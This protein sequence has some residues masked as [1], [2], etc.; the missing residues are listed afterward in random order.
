MIR[1]ILQ[2]TLVRISDRPGII[3][4]TG[5]AQ[6]S[7]GGGD[8]PYGLSYPDAP[9]GCTASA[10]SPLYA[11]NSRKLLYTRRSAPR[12]RLNDVTA[13]AAMAQSVDA[14]A[15]LAADGASVSVTLAEGSASAEQRSD[16]CV[17][18]SLVTRQDAGAPLHLQPGG[19]LQLVFAP[20]TAP[21]PVELTT[22]Y[23][24]LG[25]DDESSAETPV[26]ELAGLLADGTITA[27]TLCW[28]ETTV[29]GSSTTF[30]N[31]VTASSVLGLALSAHSLVR[32][33]SHATPGFLAAVLLSVGGAQ[34]FWSSDGGCYGRC[35]NG[36][37]AGSAGDGPCDDGNTACCHE[38]NAYI[39]EIHACECLDTSYCAPQVADATHDEC[40]RWQL[41]AHQEGWGDAAMRIHA[42]GVLQIENFAYIDNNFVTTGVFDACL[43]PSRCY[44]ITVSG[45]P[46]ATW[47]IHDALGFVVVE[48]SGPF[49]HEVCHC[50]HYG[51]DACSDCTGVVAPAGGTSGGC[52]PDG[53]ILHGDRCLLT[54]AQESATLPVSCFNGTIRTPTMCCAAGT[55]WSGETDATCEQCARG[56]VDIDGNPWTPCEKCPA[57]TY[58]NEAGA[59]EC[60]DCDVGT[61]AIVGSSL[62]SNCATG[63]YDGDSNP[64]TP[65]A[66]CPAGTYSDIASATACKP[67][68]AATHST[69]AAT[70][71][72]ILIAPYGPHV[73]MSENLV[74][75]PVSQVVD[76]SQ[77]GLFGAGDWNGDG[78][79]DA[80]VYLREDVANQILLSD[81]HGFKNVT[82]TLMERTDR[83]D[84]RPDGNYRNW[85]NYVDAIPGDWNGD[86]MMDALVVNSG[87]E[88]M[89][90]ILIADGQENFTSRLLDRAWNLSIGISA[91]GDWN[92]DGTMDVLFVNSV[93]NG[94]AQIVNR[95]AANEIL[96]FNGQGNFTSTLMER[97]NRSSASTDVVA[98]DWNG[99]GMMDALV[100]NVDLVDFSAVSTMF[101]ILMSDG[102][103]SFTSRLM[104]PVFVPTTQFG[105]S[106]CPPALIAGDWNGDGMMDALVANC[107]ADPMFEVLISNGQGTFTSMLLRP[108]QLVSNVMGGMGVL[109]SPELTAGDWNGDGMMDALVLWPGVSAEILLSNGQGS[110]DSIVYEPIESGW[111]SS[112]GSSLVALDTLTHRPVAGDWNGD[113]RTDFAYAGK[114]WVWRR[115]GTVVSTV[116]NRNTFPSGV[117]VGDWNGDGM[118]DALVVNSDFS[119][120]WYSFIWEMMHAQSYFDAANEILLSDGQ[121]SFT[122]TLMDR[123]D[124]SASPIAADWNGDGM[125]DLLVLDPAGFEI[126]LSDGQDFASSGE[127]IVPACAGCDAS[128]VAGDW[129]SDGMMDALVV[130]RAGIEILLSDGQGS[131]TSTLMER[132]DDS[133]GVVAGD[134]NSDGM[135][136]ALVVN[137]AGIEILLSDGQGNFTSTLMGRSDD[138]TGVV[139]GDWNGD[140]MMDAFVFGSTAEVLISDGQGTFNSTLVDFVVQYDR[141]RGAAAGDWNGDGMMDVLVAHMGENE[142]LL[143]DGQGSFTSTRMENSGMESMGVAAGDFN[144]D[145]TMHALIV[146]AAEPI[147]HIWYDACPDDGYSPAANAFFDVTCYKCPRHTTDT[148]R[149]VQGCQLC[150]AGKLGPD[151]GLGRDQR[152][153]CIP[154]EAGTARNLT[155]LMCGECPVGKYAAAG[156]DLCAVCPAGQ[157]TKTKSSRASGCIQCGAGSGPNTNSTACEP[158]SGSQYSISGQCQDCA[159]PHVVNAERTACSACPAGTGPNTDRTQCISC[160]GATY[161]TIGQCQE[162]AAPN[163]VDGAHQ[164]CFACSPG[165]EPNANRT[166]C[167]DCTDAM[168][169]Q[170]GVRC[171][172]CDDVVDSQATRCF[173]CS[174]GEGPNANG[175]A[176]ELCSGSQYGIMGRCQDC[177]TPHVVNA[178]RTAC[179]ACPA[180]TGPN[181]DRTQC[182]S[183]TGATYST[184]GQ[185][186]EC[187][188]PNVVDGAHQ[189]CF[190]CSP[191]EEPNVNRTSCVQCKGNKVALVGICSLCSSARLANDA[192]TECIDMNER[193]TALTD[194]QVVED[195]LVQNTS[196]TL[197]ETSLIVNTS[198]M[199][200]SVFHAAFKTDLASA[201]RLRK[202]Q[203][204]IEVSELN[205]IRRQLQGGEQLANA[206]QVTIAIE[207]PNVIDILRSLVWQLE[208][209]SSDFRMTP[210]GALVT[211]DPPTFAFVCPQGMMRAS[212]TEQCSACPGDE[213]ATIDQIGCKLCPARTKPSH[214][215]S[216]C[217]CEDGSYSIRELPMI[218]CFDIGFV[219]DIRLE[220]NAATGCYQCPAVPKCLECHVAESTQ[221]TLGAGYRFATGDERVNQTRFAFKCPVKS[222]CPAQPLVAQQTRNGVRLIVN[223][224]STGHTGLLCAKCLSGWKSNLKGVCEQCSTS[225]GWTNPVL[226]LLIGF[227]IVYIT[228]RKL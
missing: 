210:T 98:G 17:M 157:V 109:G 191:G 76:G 150:P 123:S 151:A 30:G 93:Y 22:F 205:T 79:M 215:R 194:I 65:C 192:H 68:P 193:T 204:Q 64:S 146:N 43:H 89:F 140:G 162:C 188:A 122:S 48:G 75:T 81:G 36:R 52:D 118:M 179:S 11:S 207:L 221:V 14:A 73:P 172:Q 100:V 129:N 108:A 59:T 29:D 131:F 214:D 47:S 136:D 111:G 144:G 95:G 182:I 139:A 54:C 8:A 132:S 69:R 167:V 96:L 105:D 10:R 128:G 196:N 220:S 83:G 223:N 44:E 130:N 110:F 171:Q 168:Y 121:G 19:A 174:P 103:G 189:T 158:C 61:F 115:Q 137:G 160:T 213:V 28:R 211:N 13:K 224:C 6:N 7:A 84:R 1:T 201:L 5:G 177:A 141:L 222:A 155:E 3:G 119:D 124:F 46:S 74:P 183:C 32:P 38:E 42:A 195:V 117:V 55:Q 91:A 143:S 37:W 50:G 175:T 82:S 72:D 159:T 178:E 186:Q 225:K 56:Q 218:A 185:C 166:A 49:D 227:I 63:T 170:F 197:V 57:G 138:S 152:N 106:L 21:E 88:P 35:G 23:Y 161:S 60:I 120:H 176:C 116:M 198:K 15:Q 58:S 202:N 31:F 153:F 216:Q 133:T 147:E 228:M 125:T 112:L 62:C 134:W 27:E 24:S 39:D 78:M 187:A 127:S 53:T 149:S 209:P 114:I 45:P 165:E 34:T 51:G 173:T 164:T 101:E 16:G 71:C 113:G 77:A 145:G 199:R 226:L 90:E 94:Y 4:Y 217:V 87:S 169:S 2:C 200:T 33:T 163:V 97:T 66:L 26:S 85:R 18:L 203:L 104:R 20:P 206:S 102:Q 92:G 190:A 67:C 135:M 219:D 184:I 41:T 142:I 80:L 148:W 156:A 40:N 180:G 107:G 126:L 9:A 99:D 154:C 70:Q 25:N 86:G 208:R 181:T 12:R 212:G